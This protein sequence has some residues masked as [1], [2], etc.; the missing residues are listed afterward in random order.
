MNLKFAFSRK[1]RF[2]LVAVACA[3]LPAASAFGAGTEVRTIHVISNG[4]HTSVVVKRQD[5]ASNNIPE[6]ADFP[7][8]K[9]MEFGWGDAEY[10]PAKQT[11]FGMTMRAAF[12]ST[13]AVM[14]VVGS[15]RHPTSRYPTAEIIELSI[16]PDGLRNLIQYIHYSFE[17]NHVDREKF[18]DPGLYG[19]SMF[20]PA[21]GS[22]H[23]GNTCNSWTAKAL[24]AAG[25]DV[26]SAVAS[27]AADLMLQL[28][29]IDKAP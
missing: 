2:L 4:W 23:I 15:F 14:H 17:R 26:D 11:T 24:N 21:T 5:I 25:F 29:E 7:G 22:F 3:N 10:F 8:A 12:T 9:Y 1:I 13:P 6:L 28:R 16:N 20:Y 27:P 19:N 18:S